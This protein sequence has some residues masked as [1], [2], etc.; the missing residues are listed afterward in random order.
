MP[1]AHILKPLLPVKLLG[2]DTDNDS[3]FMNE[4]VVEYCRTLGTKLTPSRDYLNNNQ[5]WIEQN[6]GAVVRRFVGHQ[7]L[8]GTLA[9]LADSNESTNGASPASLC[10]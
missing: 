3:A 2:I 1:R 10:S 5:A 9:A 6:N 8:R 7:R 4:T